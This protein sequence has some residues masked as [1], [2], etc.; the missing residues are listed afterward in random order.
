MQEY[1]AYIMGSDGHVLE[2]VDLQCNDEDEAIELAKQLV[3]AATSSYGS[4][5]DRSGR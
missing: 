3:T 1:R 2:R 5:I 4:W